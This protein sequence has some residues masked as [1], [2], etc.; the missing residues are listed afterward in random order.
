MSSLVTA[1][2]RCVTRSAVGPQAG[3][4]VATPTGP[5]VRDI[6]HICCGCEPQLPAVHRSF[7][8]SSHVRDK[9]EVSNVAFGITG[10]VIFA[11]RRPHGTRT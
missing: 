2:F 6:N 10:G 7:I 5:R 11:F 9:V 1:R 8:E 3:R 4:I